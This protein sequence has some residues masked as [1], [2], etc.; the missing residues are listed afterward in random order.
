MPEYTIAS[1]KTP[2]DARLRVI[3][4]EEVDLPVVGTIVF[5]PEIWYYFNATDLRP[6]LGVKDFS[7]IYPYIGWQKRKAQTFF[8]F[9]EYTNYI[10]LENLKIILKEKN[11]RIPIGGENWLLSEIIPNLDKFT[12]ITATEYYQNRLNGIWPN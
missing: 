3:K 5:T 7:G 2:Y 4:S 11:L 6:V 8:Q 1:I 12:Y 9:V 10:T